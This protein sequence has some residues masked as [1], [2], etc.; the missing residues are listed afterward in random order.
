MFGLQQAI[1]SEQSILFIV[2]LV[3]G[4][5]VGYAVIGFREL[6]GLFQLVLCGSN[7]E[8]RFASMVAE[9]RPWQLLLVTTL[10]GLLIGLFVH[11]VMP[12]RP[13]HGVA[14]VMEACVLRG[15]RMD[16]KAGL[17]AALASAASIGV[18]ASVGREGPAV[19]IGESISAWMAERLHFNRD[20]SLTLVGCGGIIQCADRRG[21]FCIGGGGRTIRIEGVCTDRDRVGSR[22]RRDS[23]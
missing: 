17:G 15:G 14:D 19:H 10:G 9:F 4:V 2:A 22:Y 12:G 1:R 11:Y 13:N 5:A 23:N 20:L 18:G 21:P 7:S 6:I 16:V 8:A 3:I